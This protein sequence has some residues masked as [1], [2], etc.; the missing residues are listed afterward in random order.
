MLLI[1][2]FDQISDSEDLYVAFSYSRKSFKG[3][4]NKSEGRTL[5][6]SGL[7]Y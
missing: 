1:T 4:K 3:H 6:M 7:A 5:A 2:A